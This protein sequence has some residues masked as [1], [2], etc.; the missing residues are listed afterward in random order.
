MSS[1]VMLLHI[2]EKLDAL[3]R[4]T[5]FSNILFQISRSSFWILLT[6]LHREHEVDPRVL[7]CCPRTQIRHR[8]QVFSAY[9]VRS[10][11]NKFTSKTVCTLLV[12]NNNSCTVF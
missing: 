6:F 5:A 11:K 12:L 10:G 9:S 2:S 8:R 4:L 1:L 7:K 3:A